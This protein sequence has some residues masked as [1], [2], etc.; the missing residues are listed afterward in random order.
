MI[1]ITPAVCPSGWAGTRP[2]HDRT[3][4]LAGTSRT[5]PDCLWSITRLR[6]KEDKVVVLLEQDFQGVS[7]EDAQALTTDMDARENPPSG[8]IAHVVTETAKGVHVVDIWESTA[9]VQRFTQE[10]L[11]PS[12]KKVSQERGIQMPDPIPEPKITEAYDLVRGS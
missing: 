8:L 7:R 6:V 4:E 1:L 10:Q 3:F 5:G 9:D 12:M 11:I 2:S